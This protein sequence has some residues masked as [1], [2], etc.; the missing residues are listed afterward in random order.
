MRKWFKKWY[1]AFIFPL[2]PLKAFKIFCIEVEGDSEEEWDEWLVE[3]HKSATLRKIL[4]N[5]KP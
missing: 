5:K 4:Q 1:A 2:A 3:I